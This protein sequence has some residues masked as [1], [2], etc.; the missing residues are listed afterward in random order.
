VNTLQDDNSRISDA[1]AD[2]WLLG[3]M[4]VGLLVRIATVVLTLADTS[5][6]ADDSVYIRRAMHFL[7]TGEL[8]PGAF[9]RPPLYILVLAAMR[10]LSLPFELSW[11]LTAKVL[12][13]VAGVATAI[14]VYRSARRVAGVRAAR[15]ASAFLLLDPTLIAYAHLLWPEVLFSM[16]VAFVFDGIARLD[17]RPRWTAAALGIVIGLAMLL[18]PVFGIFTL[19]LAISW[20][21][22][23]GLRSAI[24]LA[25]IVG[26]P[27]ALVISPW[28]IRNQL[29]YGPSILLENQGAYNLWIGNDPRPPAEIYQEWYALRGDPVTQTRTGLHRGLE[30]IQADPVRFLG[31]SAVRALN[32]WG[33]EYFVVRHMIFGGYGDITKG[34]LLFWFWVIQAGYALALLSAAAGLAPVYQDRSLRLVLIYAVVLTI[35]VSAMVATTRFRVPLGFLL[36]V[37]AGIGASKV[38]EQRIQGRGLAAVA[39]ALL[40]LGLSASRPVFRDIASARFEAMAELRKAEWFWFRY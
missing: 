26:A 16:L 22:R 30:A 4:A 38:L 29:R 36:S 5:L 17:Q 6:L 28:V 7:A 35:V 24:R 20:F 31:C 9:V 13:C 2:R 10:S 3:L 21:L 39:L 12:Q 32:L 1:L 33:L 15:F 23:L 18:K 14:P 27:A 37:A 25:L 19:I 40:V 11:T 34:T 8:G